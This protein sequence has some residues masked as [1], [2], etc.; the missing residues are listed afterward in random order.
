MSFEERLLELRYTVALLPFREEIAEDDCESEDE[1]IA[2]F[3]GYQQDLER[4]EFS[5]ATS[6]TD[7]SSR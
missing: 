1:E 7:G 2:V 3:H 4:S 6:R 5:E